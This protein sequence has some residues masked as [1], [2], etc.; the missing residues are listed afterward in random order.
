[1]NIARPCIAAMQSFVNLGASPMKEL[2]WDDL[3]VIE[4][5][6]AELLAEIKAVSSHE[7]FCANLVWYGYGGR[8][9][10]K[11]RM[12]LLVGYYARKPELRTMDAY[13]VAYET[14]YDLL[15]DCRHDGS[16]C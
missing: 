3:V 8:P 10:F 11:K 12:S 4:P 14:C 13:D 9:G 15:P 5:A 1:M 16:F 7:N 2:T 6:L